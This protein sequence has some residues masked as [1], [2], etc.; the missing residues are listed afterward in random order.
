MKSILKTSLIATALLVG[1]LALAQ[2]PK[3]GDGGCAMMGEGLMGHSAMGMH[4]GKGGMDPSRMQAMMDQRHAALKKKLGITAAQESAWTAFVDAHKMPASMMQRP[5]DAADMAK[6][7]TPERLDKMQALR[8]QRQAEMNKLMDQRISATK[9][10]YAALTP[11]QQK[12]FDAHSMTA[13]HG[14]GKMNH[15]PMGHG[16][17]GPKGAMQPS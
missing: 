2:G 11:E 7:T 15:G 4:Q 9:A 13:R 17:Q 14:Q 8:Q 5:A 16:M 3:G 6:L 12:I 1:G 10:L